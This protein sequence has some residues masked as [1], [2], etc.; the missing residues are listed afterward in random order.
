MKELIDRAEL[1]KLLFPM[2]IPVELPYELEGYSWDYTI[3]ARAI[4]KAVMKCKVIE[5]DDVQGT[6][7]ESVDLPRF[8]VRA[9]LNDGKTTIEEVL[10]MNRRWLLGL[11]RIGPKKADEIIEMLEKQGYDCEKLKK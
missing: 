3:S 6:H 4:Y 10:R 7:I 5:Y 9:F 2:G 11:M 8:A 1:V